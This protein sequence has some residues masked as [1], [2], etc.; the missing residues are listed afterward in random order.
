MK[1]IIAYLLLWV[2]ALLVCSLV[3]HLTT[4]PG[5]CL[6]HLP[7]AQSAY[8]GGV[9]GALYRVRAVYLNRCV[10]NRWSADWTVGPCALCCPKANSSLYG[11]ASRGNRSGIDNTLLDLE[12]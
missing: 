7:M 10:H 2:A 1:K 9:G 12:N 4:M 6:D 8:M 5:W 11:V 3:P